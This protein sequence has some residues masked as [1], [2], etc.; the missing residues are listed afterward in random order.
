PLPWR[1]V[2]PHLLSADFGSGKGEIARPARAG[3]AYDRA[4][5]TDGSVLYRPHAARRRRKSRG[6]LR[7][8]LQGGIYG[9]T[10]TPSSAFLAGAHTRRNRDPGRDRA[11][12]RWAAASLRFTKRRSQQRSYSA[13]VA[14]R[15]KPSGGPPCFAD[16]RLAADGTC[17]V[18]WGAA[19]RVA[20]AGCSVRSR[21]ARVQ[22]LA[23]PKRLGPRRTVTGERVAC[24]TCSLAVPSFRGPEAAGAEL[25]VRRQSA[26]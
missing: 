22:A 25:L 2:L 20:D 10:S 8:K 19:G 14:C 3:I 4:E 13:A 21:G 12:I 1:F 16:G 11:G 9:E 18:V 15:G 24:D 5:G 26:M 17:R 6:V 23:G 7:A